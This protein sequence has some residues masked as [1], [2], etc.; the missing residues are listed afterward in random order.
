MAYTLSTK[1]INKAVEM[2]LIK[3]STGIYYD[4]KVHP[5]TYILGYKYLIS[6]SLYSC[7]VILFIIAILFS[8][9]Y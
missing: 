2:L 6:I 4:L 3:S 8:I 5:K 7:L 9:T 1:A